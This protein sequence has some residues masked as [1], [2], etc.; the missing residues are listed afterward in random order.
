MKSIILVIAL[1]AAGFGCKKDKASAPQGRP[2]AQVDAL[3][4][5]AQALVSALGVPEDA[6]PKF[7]PGPL[8]EGVV[9]DGLG[10]TLSHPENVSLAVEGQTARLTAEGFYPV[11][12]TVD[13]LTLE[14]AQI[15]ATVNGVEQVAQGRTSDGSKDVLQTDCLLVTCELQKPEGWYR[16]EPAEAGRAICSSIEV[17]PPPMAPA[18][19]RIS[20]SRSTGGPCP[21]GTSDLSKPFLELL[22]SAEIQAAMEK[23]WVDAVAANAAWKGKEGEA[24]VGFSNFQAPWARTVEL[25]DLEGDSAA[26]LECLRT[27]TA[28]LDEKLPTAATPEN[29][30][31]TV[32][33]YV[34]FGEKVACP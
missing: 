27:A 28:P 12:I 3:M 16:S 4:A 34:K 1:V 10:I 17:L 14:N 15:K 8:K 30:S 24:V 23:C 26:L 18:L 31:L 5:Q 19:L 33:A 21:E 7:V 11:V 20:N 6:G 29:C 2:G 25:R 22:E 9:V 13:K 32:T